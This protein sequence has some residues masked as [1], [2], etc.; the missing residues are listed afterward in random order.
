[1]MNLLFN[2]FIGTVFTP[3]DPSLPEDVTLAVGEAGTVL[4]KGWTL[5]FLI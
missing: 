3:M 2:I 5:L 4:I 1:M